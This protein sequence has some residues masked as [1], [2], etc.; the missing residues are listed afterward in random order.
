MSS[1]ELASAMTAEGELVPTQE[2]SDAIHKEAAHL[3]DHVDSQTA[4]NEA[5]LAGPCFCR[6]RFECTKCLLQRKEQIS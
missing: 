2:E 6:G 5:A 3:I 4:F 1:D